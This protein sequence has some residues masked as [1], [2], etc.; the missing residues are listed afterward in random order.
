MEIEQQNNELDPRIQV[1]TTTTTTINTITQHS[2]RASLGLCRALCI[3]SFF[4]AFHFFLGLP[5]LSPALNRC[6]FG[7]CVCT[8]FSLS[9]PLLLLVQVVAVKTTK[10]QHSCIYLV[11]KRFVFCDFGAND[12]QTFA[13]SSS[14][15]ATHNDLGRF[16][17]CN[18]IASRCAVSPFLWFI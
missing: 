2:K 6:C 15:T 18:S 13:N 11:C 16:A 7:G 17:K 12:W 4:F 3:S 9:L 10:Q 5:V 8:F 14:S 1:K